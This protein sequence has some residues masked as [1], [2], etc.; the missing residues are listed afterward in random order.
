[1]YQRN[2]ARSSKFKKMLR[3]LQGDVGSGKTL[4]ALMSAINTIEAGYK[5]IVMAPTA[6]LAKQHYL[7][8]SNLLYGTGLQTELLIGETKQKQRNDIISRLKMGMVDVLIGTHTLFQKSIE[9]PKNIGLFIIDEQHNFGVEQRVD[10]INKCKNADILM[11]SATPIPRTMVMALYG[12][13]SVSQIEHKPSNRMP[14]ETRIISSDRY[15]ELV[16]SIKRKVDNGEKAYW[17]CPLVDESEKL[18]YID[19]KT[20]AEA[21]QQVFGKENVGLI[22]GKMKQEQKDQMML[23]F[24]NGKFNLLVATTVIEV[25]IDVPEA[26]IIVIENAEKF[27]L[28]QLHQLRGRVGRGSKQSYCFLLYGEKLTEIGQQ[29]LKIL[30]NNNDGFKIAE[31]DLKMRGGGVILSSKQSGFNAMEFVNF[32]RDKDLVRMLNN[33]DLCGVPKQKLAPIIDIFNHQMQDGK[34][35]GEC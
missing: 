26:T 9:M 23:D 6:I 19:A 27:G 30:R 34:S 13:V 4:V 16:K 25:G 3:I 11:M 18:D 21:L 31:Y 7:T 10:L 12:D 2:Q 20:R 35:W 8:F 15:D 28:A 22:H 29:R 14:I 32:A 17:V 33:I 5:V 24:K 1:M